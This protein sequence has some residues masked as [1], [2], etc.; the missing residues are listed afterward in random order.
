MIALWLVE[1]DHVTRVLAS[2]WPRSITWLSDTYLVQAAPS[3]RDRIS[4]CSKTIIVFTASILSPEYLPGFAHDH[5]HHCYSICI[6]QSDHIIF[7]EPNWDEASSHPNPFE[8]SWFSFEIFPFKAFIPPTINLFNHDHFLRRSN[9]V[10]D[11]SMMKQIFP[12]TQ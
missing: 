7:A 11:K 4:N 5:K 1:L 3:H 12:I 10:A 9:G 6:S 8:S 2:D